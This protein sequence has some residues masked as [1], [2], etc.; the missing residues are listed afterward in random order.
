[1]DGTQGLSRREGSGKYTED[2]QHQAGL[3]A[4]EHRLGSQETLTWSM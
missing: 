4:K 3:P 2:H 1:M